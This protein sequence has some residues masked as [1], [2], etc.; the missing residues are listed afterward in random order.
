MYFFKNNGAVRGC[1][2][3][4]QPGTQQIKWLRKELERARKENVRV[5][6]IGHI[7]PLQKNY[8]RSCFYEYGK[9]ALK[10]GDVIVGQLFGHN[11]LDHFS[12]ISKDD[13]RKAKFLG[14]Q[15]AGN[16]TRNY[17][18]K[19][20]SQ[21]M[22]GLSPKEILSAHSTTTSEISASLIDYIDDLFDMYK[23]IPPRED[24]GDE[25]IVSR[26]YTVINVSPSVVPVFNPTLRVFNY[27]L[28]NGSEYP[29]GVPL[30][31]SQFWLNAT[32]YNLQESEEPAYELEYSTDR[33]YQLPDLKIASWLQLG[34]RLVKEEKIRRRYLKYLFV[35]TRD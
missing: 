14:S 20:L 6:I 30:S 35:H 32:K 4:R 28:G 18:Q 7:A 17:R 21:G 2:R 27:S 16:T 13:L 8:F 9:L 3:K 24:D 23:N 1:S 33:D 26:E 5:Y 22:E 19:S 10:Y 11:N 34:R 29:F 25:D 15:E 12:L 31:Y